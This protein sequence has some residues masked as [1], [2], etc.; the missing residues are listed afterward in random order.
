MA[1]TEEGGSMNEG[2]Q[3][4]DKRTVGRPVER[5]MPEPIPDTPENIA[6]ILMSTEPP[7][8]TYQDEESDNQDEE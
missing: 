3:K 6:R 2:Q 1:E 4:P 8:W 5:K 7:E